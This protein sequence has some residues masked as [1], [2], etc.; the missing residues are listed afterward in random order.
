M[1]CDCDWAGSFLT[2]GVKQDLV[3]KVEILGYAKNNGDINEKMSVLI[4]EKYKGK[5]TRKII[6]V[7]GDNGME[8]RPYVDQFKVGQQYF[9]ALTKSGNDYYQ[10]N[11]GE[12]YLAIKDG[13]VKSEM[14][15]RPGL[16]Q[17]GEMNLKE[18]ETNL[19]R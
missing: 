17:T 11:C 18:F 4:I 14:N 13:K 16:P 9:L 19:K 6:T 10:N 12:F 7:W 1:S 2:V 5:E 3:V 15:P 8:C